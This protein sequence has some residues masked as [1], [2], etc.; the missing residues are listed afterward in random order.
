MASNFTVISTKFYDQLINGTGL[1]LNPTSFNTIITGNEGDIVKLI[2]RIE[3]NVTYGVSPTRSVSFN[4]LAWDASICSFTWV[5][6][7]YTEGF[8]IGASIKVT[9][10]VNSHTFTIT[11]I[12]GYDN[13]DII[14]SGADGA[15]INTWLAY[16]A[17]YTDLEFRLLSKPTYINYKYGLNK[18]TDLFPSYNSYIDSNSLTYYSPLIA[19]YPSTSTMIF[20]GGQIGASLGSV[21]AAWVSTAESFRFLYEIQHTFKIPFYKGGE[22]TNLTLGTPTPDLLGTNTYRYDNRFEFG[23]PTYHNSI[24]ANSGFTGDVGYFDENFNGKADNYVI[25]SVVISNAS[26]TGVL[27]ATEVNTVTFTVT[28]LTDDFQSGIACMAGHSKLPNPLEYQNKTTAFNTIWIWENIRNTEGAAATSGTIIE[29]F[30]F[31]INGSNAKQLDVTYTI[32]LSTDQQALIDS[33][34]YLLWFTV[35]NTN[36]TNPTLIDKVNKIVDVNQYSKNTDITGL[37]TVHQIDF[38]PSWDAFDGQSAYTNFTGGDGDLWGARCTFK[39]DTVRNAKLRTATFKVYATDGVTEIKLINKPFSIGLP[40]ET[41]DGTY[42]YQL[43]D[44]DYE[45]DLNLPS[46]EQINRMVGTIE[47]PVSLPST[48]QD[49]VLRCGF[50]TLWRDWIENLTVPLTFYDPSKPNNNRNNKTSNYSGLI[51]YEI[52]GAFEVRIA[53][54]V[55]D[56]ITLYRIIS[57]ESNILDFD[58]AG[59]TGFTGDTKV[60]NLDGV[61]VGG[62]QDGVDRIVK[63][64]FT[65]SLGILS[66]ANLAGEIWIEHDQSTSK[67]CY[68]GTYRD[69]TSD[70]NMLQPS[71]TLGVG[72][73]SY[74]EVI[75][76]SN[77]VTL[78]CKT[79]SANILAGGT[80][81]IYGKLWNKA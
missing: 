81:N 45:S 30:E 60:Y 16:D 63:V 2:Q 80:A 64:F 5:N 14:F 55:N 3:V 75:S 13:R 59:W 37:I 62:V 10:G 67:P 29:D 70:D 44:L 76:A 4:E 18:T 32:I 46:G 33:S 28:S 39:L 12:S 57:D 68:L 7:A 17:L 73:I 23:T 65:H 48:T 41:S 43:L 69:W 61:E 26:G 58:V 71:D 27:E 38:F 34:N 1:N 77:L 74:V 50:Q 79:N 9:Q 35:A 47:L 54:D 31:S 20:L 36:L 6:N 24:F 66:L 22:Y 40:L 21:T 72:N 25:G 52:Y 56:D 15:T 19:T 42:T 49:V 51:G 53:S 78:I 8:Y 11:G